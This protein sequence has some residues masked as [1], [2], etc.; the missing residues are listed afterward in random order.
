MLLEVYA[1]GTLVQGYFF[2]MSTV[3]AIGTAVQKCLWISVTVTERK[4]PTQTSRAD[5]APGWN[6]VPYIVSDMSAFERVWCRSLKYAFILRIASWDICTRNFLVKATWLTKRCTSDEWKQV[7]ACK[8]ESMSKPF[9][10]YTAFVRVYRWCE[11]ILETHGAMFM[12]LVYKIMSFKLTR[13]A[14]R[15][16]ST[17]RW[18]DERVKSNQH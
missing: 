10:K 3:H 17:R 9:K 1:H 18:R 7:R 2:W 4:L 11:R 8:C 14:E 13:L 5:I 16:V 12:R 15:P 6:R